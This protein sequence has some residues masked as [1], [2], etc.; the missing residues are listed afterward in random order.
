MNRYFSLASAD[1]VVPNQDA[2][3]LLLDFQ[4]LRQISDALPGNTPIQNKAL[5]AANK[6]INVFDHKHP[7]TVIECRKIAEGVFGEGWQEKG[8]K[9]YEEGIHKESLVWG[10]G[11][12]HIDTAWY[13]GFHTNREISLTSRL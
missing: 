1:L 7:S 13:G 10:I 2:W 9:I 3:N 12:C 5:V 6:I 4:T 8:E 11:H